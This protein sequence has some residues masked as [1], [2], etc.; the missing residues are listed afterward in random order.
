MNIT[1]VSEHD[2]PEIQALAELVLF[3]NVDAPDSEK[4]FLLPHI[5][6]DIEKY[7]NDP[8][9]VYLKAVEH[10]IVGYILFKECWNLTHLFI[11]P[12]CQNRGIGKGL[13]QS[14]IDK[15]KANENRGYI[16]LNSSKNAVLFY[17]SMGFAIDTARERKSTSSTPMRYDF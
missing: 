5:K 8:M 14:G 3:E 4:E 6:S 17:E 15:I 11:A 10:D 1:N 12:N 7:V 13:L 9:S 2:L 16:C